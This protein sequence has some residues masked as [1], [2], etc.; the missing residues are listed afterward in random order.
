MTVVRLASGNLILHSPC[1]PC[2]RLVNEIAAV[3]VVT[4]VIAP[5]WFH[6]LYLSEYR[7]RYPSA[8]FWGPRFLKRLQESNV[9]ELLD[10]AVRPP[11]TE[12][13]PHETLSS[14]F[15][16]DESVFYHP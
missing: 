4:D 1:C 10:G 13:L 11:W 9:D 2:D 6:D 12:K 3:G 14:L 5:N 16:F 15:S 7:A 8:R